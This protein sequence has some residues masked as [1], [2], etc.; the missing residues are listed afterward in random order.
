MA[1]VGLII[2]WWFVAAGLLIGLIA[3]VRWARA[4]R[5]EMAELPSETS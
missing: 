2:S 3:T 1:V 5:A 4:A